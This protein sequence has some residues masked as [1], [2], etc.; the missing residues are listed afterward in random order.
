MNTC[1]DSKT[2]SIDTWAETLRQL[3]N[4]G[5]QKIFRRN[6][7]GIFLDKYTQRK[8]FSSHNLDTIE[9]ATNWT[10]K[11]FLLWYATWKTSALRKNNI[12][13]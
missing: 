8:D 2:H 13:L 3:G 12:K 10:E 11:D 9:S 1:K 7:L 4:F 6:H 5:F